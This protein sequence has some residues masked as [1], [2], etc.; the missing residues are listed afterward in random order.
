M[1]LYFNTQIGDCSK[2]IKQI[3]NWKNIFSQQGRRTEEY[4]M[5]EFLINNALGYLQYLVPKQDSQTGG[6]IPLLYTSLDPYNL[7]KNDPYYKSY[8]KYKQ[9]YKQ[10]KY[11]RY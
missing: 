6:K 4:C 5:L 7:S 1:S 11:L 2:I 8:K 3:T 9:K 10:I